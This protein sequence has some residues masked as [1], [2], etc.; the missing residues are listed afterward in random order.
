MGGS[1]LE[2]AQSGHQTTSTRR[3]KVE[4]RFAEARSEIL[5]VSEQGRIH[6]SYAG[7]YP[8]L[9]TFACW[10]SSTSLGDGPVTSKYSFSML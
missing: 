3:W 2:S 1:K 7:R 4:Q 10:Q 8:F 9:F 5:E 6:M